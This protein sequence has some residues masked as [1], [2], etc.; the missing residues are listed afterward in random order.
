MNDAQVRTVSRPRRNRAMAG[1]AASKALYGRI[2]IWSCALLASA[3]TADIVTVDGSGIFTASGANQFGSGPATIVDVGY[4][5][6]PL[7]LGFQFDTGHF[8][9]DGIADTIVGSFGAAF[10]ARFAGRA[11]LEVGYYFDSGS[12]DASYPFQFGYQYLDTV[13]IEEQIQADP[14][15]NRLIDFAPSFQQ[16][17]DTYLRTEF[18]EVGAYADFV[19][20]LEASARVEGC[21]FGCV[22]FD[23]IPGFLRDVSARQELFSL[24]RPDPET[25]EPNGQISIFGTD[26]L[27][28]EKEWELGGQPSVAGSTN[29]S[30]KAGG[31]AGIVVEVSDIG[32]GQPISV[33][34]GV[35][36]G[37]IS[38][39]TE[40]AN[41]T[42]R[43][44]SEL[45]LEANVDTSSPVT[46]LSAS[47]SD[48]IVDL[49]LDVDGLAAAVLPF[50]PP[51]EV[52]L[53]LGPAGL[54]LNILDYELGPQLA[55]SQ[56]VSL[57][58]EPTLR[59]EFDQQINV[60]VN[61]ERRRTDVVDLRLGEDETFEI[62][63]PNRELNVTPS[64]SL[65]PKLTNDLDLNLTLSQTLQALG[66]S[67]SFAGAE[68]FS[69]G[70]LI[71][72]EDELART[73]LADLVDTRFD[74]TGAI[75]DAVNVNLQPFT[76]GDGWRLSGE[77]ADVPRYAASILPDGGGEYSFRF[78]GTDLAVGEETAYVSYFGS[79]GD[80]YRELFDHTF[81]ECGFWLF[82]CWSWSTVSQTHT[83]E[84]TYAAHAGDPPSPF[85]ASFSEGGRTYS[86]VNPPGS[87]VTLP[88]RTALRISDVNSAALLPDSL[89]DVYAST[90]GW[91]YFLE[92]FRYAETT[93]T[94]YSDLVDI[95]QTKRYD[96]YGMT[97]PVYVAFPLIETVRE[98]DDYVTRFAQSIDFD[99]ADYVTGATQYKLESLTLPGDRFH[100]LLGALGDDDGL[101]LEV[102][103]QTAGDWI[104]LA[105]W[106]PTVNQDFH[107][108]FYD[109][110][111]RGL[112][113]PDADLVGTMGTWAADG[114]SGFRLS[115]LDIDLGLA[116]QDWD[117]LLDRFGPT[118]TEPLIAGITVTD[119]VKA[120][121]ILGECVWA[122]CTENGSNPDTLQ[123][124]LP[125]TSPS[126]IG[127]SG[128]H[129]LYYAGTKET[130]GDPTAANSPGLDLT[131]RPTS[132]RELA[133]SSIPAIPQPETGL[134]ERYETSVNPDD[135]P[136]EA[137]PACTGAGC[138]STPITDP[139]TGDTIAVGTGIEELEAKGYANPTGEPNTG[140]HPPPPPQTGDPVPPPG[141]LP[142][143]ALSP[144]GRIGNDVFVYDFSQVDFGG[145]GV[146]GGPLPQRDLVFHGDELLSDGT[147]LCGEATASFADGQVVSRSAA[148]SGAA[149]VRF[150]AQGRNAS[151]FAGCFSI[152]DS[153]AIFGQEA[154]VYL[155]LP[156]APTYDFAVDGPLFSSVLLPYAGDNAL[157]SGLIDL[158]LF[159]MDL[160]D[161]VRVARLGL[162]DRYVFDGAGVDRFRLAGL[163]LPY[164]WLDHSPTIT[165]PNPLL[166]VGFTL[167][168][169]GTVITARGSGFPAQTPEPPSWVLILA[170]ALLGRRIRQ[171][172]RRMADG[173]GQVKALAE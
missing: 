109:D 69:A 95:L 89:K 66:I 42:L 113:G 71:T 160:D 48:S 60:L 50:I 148:G 32:F 85:P 154:P 155:E 53:N 20:D 136:P 34:A 110:Y 163:E 58:P 107:F 51:G 140:Q 153:M 80:T 123:G 29:Q 74:L 35:G 126:L 6:D 76:L 84:A 102:R 122:R 171:T 146:W 124:P 27:S 14:D 167:S 1:L 133:R 114:V 170:G 144:T 12:V 172:G 65:N 156:F 47:A 45:D 21:I 151:D 31:G 147:T 73:K 77:S 121:G 152:S 40:L 88:D 81:Q 141:S 143:L 149:F 118:G 162:G 161:F 11:G 82:G 104:A 135:V 37:P 116:G 3:A 168:E 44:P 100:D 22:G 96:G 92:M 25:G 111:L 132:T 52:N 24:N 97:D 63:F 17:G 38:A 150:D 62:Q 139:V 166:I 33:S 138:E 145:E 16:V 13:G 68:V 169:P 64:F 134:G 78:D 93:D 4:A 79:Q 70:P 137:T 36:Y 86:V 8:G 9:F 2:A 59:L 23:L 39:T 30:G 67:A 5:N 26:S 72:R 130:V 105:D 83:T 131:V 61:G 49:R 120:E 127:Q 46:K 165:D 7:F 28:F 128:P 19:I 94:R 10:D 57:A 54:S 75:E 117:A 159:D 103:D 41:L 157:L 55:L 90:N 106:V 91:S 112:L 18:P 108:N 125:G 164:F 173:V 99:I 158:M 43:M 142:K 101:R 15:W 129:G 98:G 56:S 87:L 119:L 115:G